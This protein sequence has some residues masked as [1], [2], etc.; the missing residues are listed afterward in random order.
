[1]AQENLHL[2]TEQLSAYLDK[3]LLSTEEQNQVEA[4]LKTCEQCQQELEDLRHTVALLHALPR[5][6]LPRSFMLPLDIN[7]QTDIQTSVED[8]PE[9]AEP[10]PIAVAA[11]RN[12]R[13]E[14]GTDNR[15]WPTY[16]RVA[17]RTVSAIAAVVGLALLLSGM[18]GTFLPGGTMTASYGRPMA[19]NSSTQDSRTSSGSGENAQGSAAPQLSPSSRTTITPPAITAT[20]RA[21]PIA[22][23]TATTAITH[24][25]TPA[26]KSV[27]PAPSIE[28]SRSP[29][30]LFFDLS[31]GPGRLGLGFLL[32]L[33]GVMGSI[34]FKR[35]WRQE[36]A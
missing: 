14:A 16:A 4:H 24:E 35:R 32:L 6:A 15:S 34:V 20:T 33:L 28:P 23:A 29:I 30:I 13:R 27:Q 18:I 21:T 36:R 3:Q 2:M 8:E 17:L 12:R 26:V 11:A 19:A 7:I 10:V 31:T 25:E 1:M 9:G 5:P 22:E